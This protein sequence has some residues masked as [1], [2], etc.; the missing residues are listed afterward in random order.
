[1]KKARIGIASLAA[2]LGASVLLVAPPAQ[3]S[4]RCIMSPI[5][6]EGVVYCACVTVAR[7]GMIVLPG[8]Q[9]SCAGPN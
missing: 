7:V 1:M 8:S 5:T 6:P 2:A 4:E 3:A 9:W